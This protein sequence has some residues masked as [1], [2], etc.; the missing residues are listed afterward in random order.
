M[1]LVSVGLDQKLLQKEIL[2]ELTVDIEANGL[3]DIVEDLVSV[4]DFAA[5]ITLDKWIDHSFLIPPSV[6][7]EV[8]LQGGIKSNEC[9]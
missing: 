4:F 7:C 2:L 3:M 8:L 6:K 1:C 5:V 9:F